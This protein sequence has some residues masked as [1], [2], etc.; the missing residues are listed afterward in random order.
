MKTKPIL[1][2]VVILAL[3]AGAFLFIRSRN[4]VKPQT[5]EINQFL[6]AF[7]NQINEGRTDSLLADFD[8][9]LKTNATAS[10]HVVV[11]LIKNT[12]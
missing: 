11:C 8:M 2:T 3:L 10:Q 6:Y 5:A 7:S 9:E 12:I 4:L 1:I